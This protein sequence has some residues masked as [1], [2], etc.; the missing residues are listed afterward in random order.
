[1]QSNYIMTIRMHFDAAHALTQ[2]PQGHP[3]RRLHG[4]TWKVHFRFEGHKLSGEGWL[5]DFKEMKDILKHIVEKLDHHNINDV[6]RGIIPTAESLAK[7][8]YKQIQ[9]SPDYLRE[10]VELYNVTVFES[11]DCSIT[12]CEEEE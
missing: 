8:F 9:I 5:V 11:D 4:H 12:Y 2:L 3:C 7:W 10:Y 6:L 1:M